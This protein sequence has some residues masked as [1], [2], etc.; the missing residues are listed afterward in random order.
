MVVRP[1]E[2]A[3]CRHGLGDAVGGEDHRGGAVRHL[4]ELADEH[5]ALPLQ[6]LDHVL[7]VDDLVADVDR[8]PV[9]GERP[10]DHVDGPHHAGAEAARGTEQDL[11]RRLR[12]YP[13]AGRGSRQ[14]RDVAHDSRDVARR[15]RPCQ[16]AHSV[17][18]PRGHPRSSE[19]GS[20]WR[21]GPGQVSAALRLRPPLAAPSRTRP[22]TPPASGIIRGSA[23]WATLKR[24]KLSPS[25]DGLKAPP[26]ASTRPRARARRATSAES[27]PV[28]QAHPQEE[29]SGRLQPRL[30]SASFQ[31]P[32]GRRHRPPQLLAD[33]GEVPAVGAVCEEP[34]HQA[35]R[36]MAVAQAH[37]ELE[38]DQRL[39]PVLAQRDEA[40][41]DGG[42]QRLREAADLDDPLQP[43]ETGQA[44]RRLTLEISEDVVLDDEGVV[45]LSELQDAVGDRRAPGW[46]RSGSGARNW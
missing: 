9:D 33:L 13:A 23:H 35:R 8:R 29:A 40:A 28:R 31:L 3:L 1:R 39:D 46:I 25:D 5:R 34:V 14:I 17:K 26:G 43:V 27:M 6:A 18:P 22:G 19:S 37:G 42:R 7:V 44:R 38:V 2:S 45:R 36:Q 16:P 12:P 10:L 24:R 15:G 21:T 30:Q 4:V 32:Q 11:Q 41:T 20:A